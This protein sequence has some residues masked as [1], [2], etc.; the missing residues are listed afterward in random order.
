MKNKILLIFLIFL[1]VGC[2]NEVE[3]EKK[4][5]KI[6][7]ISITVKDLT[8]PTIKLKQEEVSLEIGD[9]FSLSDYLI[10]VYDNFDKKIDYKVSGSAD[11]SK[12]G[13]YSIKISAKD[14]AGNASNKKIVV[15]VKGKETV[16]VETGNNNKNDFNSN[17]QNS[18]TDS[19]FP[20]P[21]PMYSKHPF[22]GKQ[23]LFSAGYDNISASQACSNDLLSV[24]NAPGSCSAIYDANG[25]PIGVQLK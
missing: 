23:Y 25:E 8:P 22:S 12:A 13:T 14:S 3:K 21:P 17:S 19:Y 7:E 10:E 4:E 11:T 16:K 9:T 15:I 24:P 18:N 6:N 1:L 2:S 5:K 20:T